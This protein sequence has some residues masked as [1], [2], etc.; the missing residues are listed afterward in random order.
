[1]FVRKKV[2]KSGVISVQVI[3]KVN[4]KSKLVKTIGSSID[5]DIVERLVLEGQQF[6]ATFGG[7]KTFDFSNESALIK[8]A[9]QSISSHN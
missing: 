1:M 6:I 3:T 2:N 4:G 5:A 8:S 9:F 7:Q